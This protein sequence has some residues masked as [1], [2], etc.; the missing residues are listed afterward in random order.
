MCDDM[1][2]EIRRS[3]RGLMGG[4]LKGAMAAAIAGGLAKTG[5]LFTPAI[6]QAQDA[7]T[8]DWWVQQDD[9]DDAL[10]EFRA[11]QIAGLIKEEH[12]DIDLVFTARAD[13]QNFDRVLA[14]ALQSGAG[15]DIVPS[16][17]P[18]HAGTMA[19]AGLLL[20][21][22]PYAD[23]YGWKEKMLP[24][25][26]ATGYQGDALYLLPNEMECT[27]AYYGQKL[28]DEKGWAPPTNRAEF[29]AWAEE[30]NGQGIIPVAA[31]IADCGL[32]TNWLITIF[33]NT[34]AG[35]DAVYQAL[36]GEIPFSEPVFVDS[37]TLLNDYMQRGWIG[38]GVEQFFST[39]FDTVH[40]MLA[41][42]EAGFAWEGTWFLSRLKNFFGEEAGNDNAWGWAQ[43][44]AWTDAVTYPTYP[45]ALGS[46]LSI[47]ADSKVADQAA[48][49]LDWYYTDPVRVAERIAAYPGLMTLPL[50][51][52]PD[53]FPEA[54]DP[55]VAEILVNLGEAT[56]SGNFGYAAWTFWPSKTHIWL[57]DEIQKV[58]TGD[59][60]PQEYCEGMAELFAEELAEGVV[61]TPIPRDVA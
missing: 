45:L 2:M 4:G 3:R 43:T 26:L 27:I 54:M 59:M 61:P 29:E 36:T 11:T 28:F 58:F 33:F 42:S 18:G 25:A 55:R 34:Y 49:V 46:T 23:Q 32:C 31:G 6:A 12:P 17:G 19:K 21:L 14:T 16:Q 52:T 1:C 41:D 24:W 30:A 20:D 7:V 56:S 50:A 9:P 40:T 13:G 44:P 5:G 35:P 51:F 15:P 60:T 10:E 22:Q 39:S 57:H 48:T 37:V 53:D 38:G 47:A 8:V